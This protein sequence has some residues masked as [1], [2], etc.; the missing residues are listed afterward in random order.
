MK[1]ALISAAALCVL[2]L[3]MVSTASG[4]ATLTTTCPAYSQLVANVTIPVTGD[5]VTDANGNVWAIA[6]YTRTLMV[7]RVTATT[8]C[9]TWRDTGTFT[10]IGSQSPGGTGYVGPGIVGKLTRTGTTNTFTGTWQPTVA[11]SGLLPPQAGPFDWTSLYFTDVQ[12]LAMNWYTS[13]YTTPLNGSWGS[14]TGYPSYC[15]IVGF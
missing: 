6:N 13:L 2:A 1:R 14:R 5:P 3:G 4:R 9:A 12:G 15:D 11:T 8:Y 10:T 7:Y